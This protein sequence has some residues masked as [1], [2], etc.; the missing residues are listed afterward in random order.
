MNFNWIYRDVSSALPS[1]LRHLEDASEVGSRA[2]RVKELTHVGIT[3]KEPWRRE[4]LVPCRR[5]NIAAQIAETMWVLGGRDDIEWLANYLPRVYD[6]SD[7]GKRW[8]A[9]YGARLR[10]WEPDQDDRGPIDQLAL[11]VDKLRTNPL[12]RQ[13]VVSI[14]DP[15]LD[16][17]PSKDIPCNNWLSFSSRNGYL[18][19]H[20]AIR[21]N[22]VIWGWSGINAFEWSALLE[23][24]AGLLGLEAGRLHFSTTSF[25]I[26]DHHWKKAANIL[27]SEHRTAA[28]ANDE[29][30]DSPRFELPPEKRSLEYFDDLVRTWFQLEEKI[31]GGVF[32][33]NQVNRFPEPMLRS[34]LRVLQWWWTGN[35]E[36]LDPLKDTRLR[37]AALEYSVQR[38]KLKPESQKTF[39]SSH[40][41][42]FVQ[43]SAALHSQKHDAYGDS[44]KRRGEMLGIMANIA[45]KIDRLGAGDTADE[46]QL[47]TA[48]DLMVYLAKYRTWLADQSIGKDLFPH[49]VTDRVASDYPYWANSLLFDIDSDH[50]VWPL[51]EGVNIKWHETALTEAF[52]ELEKFVVRDNRDRHIL[53]E[54]MLKTAYRL[55]RI[56]WDAV[57]SHADRN[58]TRSWNP[59]AGQ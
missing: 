1:L 3:L 34:W 10:G 52:T 41:S 28:Y 44:W 15:A 43:A 59:E 38:P 20:V 40:S 23:I 26:Y 39:V 24:V 35:E 7:D 17:E 50:S 18:D 48:T 57:H 16:N 42:K 47:D 14:W 11:V 33:E 55:A 22:D 54:G 30:A 56:R 36:A 49:D 8:R 21:S 19:L 37:A 4:V 51:P 9:G 6:F 25:H 45:R 53:V 29:L 2:G 32:V 27:D 5:A 31:R 12:D 13:A 58:A 46:T